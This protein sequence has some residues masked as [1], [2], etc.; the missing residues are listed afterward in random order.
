MSARDDERPSRDPHG[1]D[2]VEPDAP[3]TDEEVAAS[4]RL[5]DALE[6][7]ATLRGEP[8]GDAD[9]DLVMALR[10]A[11]SPA[12]LD[13]RAHASI[14]DEVPAKE[15]LEQ[16]A[17]LRDSLAG[18]RDARPDIVVALQAAWNPTPIAPDEHRS[19]V[20]R[21]VARADGRGIG[22]V[23]G[24]ATRARAAR[25]F[26]VTTTSI[27]ALA[28]SVLI[29]VGPSS[30]SLHGSDRGGEAPLARARSTQSLFDEP[31]RAGETSARIDRIAAARASDY[32]DN[33]FFAWGVR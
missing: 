14:L 31:F 24:A 1:D 9:L 7:P 33:R 23:D 8:S 32:R 21:A 5:R 6:A 30:S 28:A 20:E 19:I 2:S 25:V 4:R 10:A 29:W 12:R 13:A 26:V 18:S 27:L 22:A 3:P 17:E 11:W 15:E 16:A